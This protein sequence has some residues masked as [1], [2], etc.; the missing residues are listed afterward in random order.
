MEK[1]KNGLWIKKEE[2]VGFVHYRRTGFYRILFTVSLFGKRECINGVVVVFLCVC[3]CV[4]FHKKV[5][6]LR[7]AELE[8]KSFIRQT[9]TS[10]Q[11]PMAHL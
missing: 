2:E 7:E 8:N 1:W 6:Q 10:D 9:L 5:F 3:V 4:Y 11:V